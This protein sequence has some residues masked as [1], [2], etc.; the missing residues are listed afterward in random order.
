MK[1]NSKAAE[2]AC[3]GFTLT[4]LVVVTALL[5]ILLQI[6][7]PR[8]LELLSTWQRDL[9]TRTLTDHLALAR[10]E[11]IHWSRQVVMCSS[12]DA[13]HCAPPSSKEWSSGWLVFQD[14]DEDGQFGPEDKLVAVSQ[15]AT[16]IRSIR[17]NGN[18]QRFVFHPSGM[19]SSGMATLEITPRVGAAQRITVNRIGRVRLSS[20]Q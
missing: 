4:E 7:I 1:N 19:M 6:A 13:Q 20:T 8:C 15:G 16:G 11:A 17:G 14:I 9:V 12:L 2:G 10:S 3:Y 5:A 18:I